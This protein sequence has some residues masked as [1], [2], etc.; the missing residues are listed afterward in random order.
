MRSRRAIKAP[1]TPHSETR[2]NEPLDEAGA[3]SKERFVGRLVKGQHH[4][5][6]TKTRVLGDAVELLADLVRLGWMQ[7]QL[8]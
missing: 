5:F 3:M 7:E 1:T 4:M 8:N 6:A 2:A